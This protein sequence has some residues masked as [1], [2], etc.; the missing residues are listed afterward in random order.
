MCY[1]AQSLTQQALKYAIHR[2]DEAMVAQL[3]QKLQQ[4]RIDKHAYYQVSG[5]VHPQILVFTQ[6]APFEP[7]L[8]SWGLIPDWV[9]SRQAADKIKTSTLNAK[10]ETL[11]EK[12]SFKSS[13]VNKR[14]IIF[15][16]AFYEYHHI[17]KIKIPY[18]IYLPNNAIMVLAGIY[19][20]W[21]D[22]STKQLINTVSIVT[23]AGNAVMSK[24]HNNPALE[25]ARMPVILNSAQINEWLTADTSSKIAAFAK[26][27]D[28]IILEYYS[29]AKLT[30]KGA[31]G[32]VP[33]AI[34][35]MSYPELNTLF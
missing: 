23:S 28:D 6:N 4:L 26:P 12:A 21:L 9:T 31:L 10:V 3:Q 16:D 8:F 2:G 20:S 1:T 11:F 5:F 27:N 15:L 22:P 17:N 14:C 35:P 29:V 19:S 7:Q 25:M 34:K 32:N 30:G 33:A 24:I 18:R 13:V